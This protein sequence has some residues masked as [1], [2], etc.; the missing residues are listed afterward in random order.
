MGRALR[1]PMPGVVRGTVVVFGI[2]AVLFVLA[3]FLH[4]LIEDGTLAAGIFFVT[5]ALACAVAA[6]GL[7]QR[8]PWAGHL[9]I[10]LAGLLF[11]AS[12]GVFG[13]ITIVG[14]GLVVWVLW[15]LNRRESREWLTVRVRRR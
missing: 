10:V 14:V 13:A 5:L 2:L 15:A 9:V 8:R 12:L 6:A 3:A 7:V 1:S 11:A 4:M